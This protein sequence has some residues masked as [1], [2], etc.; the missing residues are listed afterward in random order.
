MIVVSKLKPSEQ[1]KKA[2]L[3]SLAELVKITKQSEQTLINWHKNKPE[4][5]A[6]LVAGAV[7]VKDGV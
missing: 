7:S 3:S 4:L 5:F 2:G 1:C 6:V